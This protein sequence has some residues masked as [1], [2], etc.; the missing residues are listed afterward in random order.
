MKG[1]N[2][3]SLM[4][5]TASMLKRY[6]CAILLQLQEVFSERRSYNLPYPGMNR[7]A[8]FAKTHPKARGRTVAITVTINPSM[9]VQR[10]TIHGN[11]IESIPNTLARKGDSTSDVTFSMAEAFDDRLPLSYKIDITV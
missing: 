6:I 8:A 2:E 7:L 4:D 3:A 1:A 9:I 5:R 11:A 10:N